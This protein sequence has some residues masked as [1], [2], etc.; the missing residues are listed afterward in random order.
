M[1]SIV[2]ILALLLASMMPAIAGIAPSTGTSA[3]VQSGAK[4]A[5][6]QEQGAQDHENHRTEPE[7]AK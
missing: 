7:N 4:I 6:K 2:S 3:A 1:K 5:P